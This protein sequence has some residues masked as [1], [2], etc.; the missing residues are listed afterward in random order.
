MG[1]KKKVFKLV[2]VA[3]RG[4]SKGK[5]YTR[6]FNSQAEMNKA[7]GGKSAQV[8]LKMP[9]LKSA[10]DFYSAAKRARKQYDMAVMEKA[11]RR[12]INAL[13]AKWVKLEKQYKDVYKADANASWA[14]RAKRKEGELK[15]LSKHGN[16]EVREFLGGIPYSPKKVKSKKVTKEFLGDTPWAP[17]KASKRKRR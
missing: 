13:K 4:S 2:V 3:T 12:D 1:A 11:P 7:L 8:A 14:S 6:Y 17:K 16:K 10:D 5:K 15:A 9:R